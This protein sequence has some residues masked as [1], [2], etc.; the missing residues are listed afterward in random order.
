MDELDRIKLEAAAFRGLIGHLQERKDVQ[1]IDIM[2]LAGFC[3]NCLSKWY[4]AAADAQGIELTKDEALEAVYGMPYS[5][6]KDK[7]QNEATPEQMD[8]FNET[9]PLHAKISGHV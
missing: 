8:K 7:Y 4:K 3:R 2:N 9:K 5:E 6:W 1:N